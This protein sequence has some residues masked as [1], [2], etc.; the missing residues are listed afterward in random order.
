MK[1]KII[2]KAY[3]LAEEF[4]EKVESSSWRIQ[5]DWTHK[6]M[7]ELMNLIEVLED[8]DDIRYFI[9]FFK[10]QKRWNSSDFYWFDWFIT[11]WM[12]QKNI[13]ECITKSHDF[14]LASIMNIKELS[15]NDYKE[16]LELTDKEL[17]EV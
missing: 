3:E 11:K 10:W 13:I 9:V 17:N 16:F 2:K 14:K 15:R 8:Q 6:K 1:D 12:I 4:I 5:L 7:K